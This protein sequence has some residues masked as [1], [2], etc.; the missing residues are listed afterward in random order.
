M[1]GFG[2]R[3]KNLNRLYDAHF[4][5][6]LYDD[7]FKATTGSLQNHYYT[8]VNVLFNSMPVSLLQYEER[9]WVIQTLPHTCQD[10]CMCNI[11]WLDTIFCVNTCHMQKLKYSRF[12]RILHDMIFQYLFQAPFIIIIPMKSFNLEI[13]AC[14]N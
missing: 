13:I 4:L 1:A 10:Q 5:S 2:A 14:Q 11:N 12:L 6:Y 9:L 8:Y 7:K 3:K